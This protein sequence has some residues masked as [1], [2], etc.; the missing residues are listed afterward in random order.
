VFNLKCSD[1]IGGACI[2]QGRFENCVQDSGPKIKTE[3][4]RSFGRSSRRREGNIITDLR[5][6]SEASLWFL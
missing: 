4:K 1:V 6:Y 5:E 2:A 3:R